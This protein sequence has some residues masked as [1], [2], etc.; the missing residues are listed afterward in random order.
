M[1][2]PVVLA[3][4]VSPLGV[5]A[6]TSSCRMQPAPILPETHYVW[7]SVALTVRQSLLLLGGIAFQ[8]DE[9]RDGSRAYPDTALGGVLLGADGAPRR[10]PRPAGAR[11]FVEPR[12][13]VRGDSVTVLW[14]ERAPTASATL[15]RRHLLAANWSTSGW[16]PTRIV[17]SFEL[18]GDLTRQLGSDLIQFGEHRWMAFPIRDSLAAETPIVLMSEKG[19]EWEARRLSLGTRLTNAVALG[20]ADGQLVAAFTGVPSGQ[21]RMGRTLS[22]QVWLSRRSPDGWTR[23]VLLGG[24]DSLGSRD[25]MLL[26]TSGGL[27][28]SWIS[29]EAE[30]VLEWRSVGALRTPS[31]AIHR[32]PGVMLVTQ[33]IEPFRDFVTVMMRDRSVH[34]LRLRADGLERV[35]KLSEAGAWTAVVAEW[36]GHPWALGPELI[37][38]RGGAAV[39]LVAHDLRCA[40]RR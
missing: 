35:A 5:G 39:R 11:A 33:G 13:F 17:G 10:V 8:F 6:Q 36:K 16:G 30:P 27:I 25:P 37:E 24:V 12:A 7:P 34:V 29:T 9:G 14:S 18:V 4:L 32:L 40:L 38:A 31:G 20:V 23:A 15:D 19:G 26:P 21:V 22:P 2:L 3:L 1:R 28:A